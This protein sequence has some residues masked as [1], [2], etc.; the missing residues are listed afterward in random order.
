MAKDA[1]EKKGSIVKVAEKVTVYMTKKSKYYTEGTPVDV[2]PLL[3]K[4]L[5]AAGKAS[6]TT[7]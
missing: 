1:D 7:P 5:I 3:A 6:E 2:H 4:K